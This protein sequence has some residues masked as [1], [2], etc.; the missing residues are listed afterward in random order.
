MRSDTNVQLASRQKLLF[1]LTA[2]GT[3]LL[4]LCRARCLI[5]FTLYSIFR[6]HNIMM[7]KFVQDKAN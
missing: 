1:Q 7:H 3:A 4:A 6:A 2:P 5:Q